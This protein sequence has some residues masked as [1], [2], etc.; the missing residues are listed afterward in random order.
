MIEMKTPTLSTQSKRNLLKF[1]AVVFGAAT[2][3]P[4]LTPFEIQTCVALAAFFTGWHVPD[5]KDPPTA[6]EAQ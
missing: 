2:Q 5:P 1:G 6:P 4:G 3:I